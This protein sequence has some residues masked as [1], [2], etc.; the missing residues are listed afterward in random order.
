[1]P[2]LQSSLVDQGY[3]VAWYALHVRKHGMDASTSNHSCNFRLIF[4]V[5]WI[6]PRGKVYDSLLSEKMG[7]MTSI[8]SQSSEIDCRITVTENTMLI[9][10]NND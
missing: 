1:M 2:F 8:V 7:H 5:Y 4:V 6:N 3:P 9:R 10:R